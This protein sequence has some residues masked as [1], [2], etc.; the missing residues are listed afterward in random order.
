MQSEVQMQMLIQEHLW[1][2]KFLYYYHNCNYILHK[3]NY[4]LFSQYILPI[5]WSRYVLLL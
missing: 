2:Q 5:F 4:F 1:Q 3:H